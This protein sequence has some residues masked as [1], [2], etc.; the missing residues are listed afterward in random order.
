MRRLYYYILIISLSCF[1]QSLEAQQYHAIHGS[2]YA[3]AAGIFNN[4]ASGVNSIY[5]WDLNVFSF[6]TTIASNHLS[7][8]NTSLTNPSNAIVSFNEG[9]N[10]HYLH[11]N[12]HL[13]LFTFQYNIDQKRSFSIGLSAKMYNHLKTSHLF[14]NDTISSNLS[15]LKANRTTPFMEGY[16]THAGWM[17]TNLNY[18][19]V[20]FESS[21]QRLSAGVT[22]NLLRGISGAFAK[23]N[24]IS[25]SEFVNNGIDTGYTL[26]SGGVNYAYS[27]NYDNMYSNTASSQLVKDFLKNTKSSIGISMGLEYTIYKN[28]TYQQASNHPT[29]YSWKF[30]LSIM[31]IGHNTFKPSEFSGKFY[32]PQTNITDPVVATKLSNISAIEILRDSL[33]TIF[34]NYDALTSNFT[35]STPTRIILNIDKMLGNHFAVNTELTLNLF[36]TANYSKLLTRELNLVTLTPKWETVLLGFYMPIQYNTQGNL[37]M[38]IACKL[39][40]LTL[41]LH[42][43]SWMKNIHTINGGGYI[44]FSLHPF[45]TKKVIS[46]FDCPA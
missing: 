6:Q 40:P 5:K 12:M 28:D 14:I 19:Q 2:S 18:S 30:G 20:L 4:P 27:T 37:W 15:F 39:G 9:R 21:N 46:R 11:Q 1:S 38:G 31:D 23:I 33:K 3:G 22:I 25:V 16:L 24:K 7:L 45:N 17:E 10:S 41:G 43:I 36:S 44:L 26:V 42:D 35:I 34:Q 13:N 8:L 32:T 29:N